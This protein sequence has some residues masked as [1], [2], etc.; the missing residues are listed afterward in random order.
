[1]VELSVKPVDTPVLFLV[2]TPTLR[3][4]ESSSPWSEIVV[5]HQPI[6]NLFEVP[7]IHFVELGNDI[8][9]L[10]LVIRIRWSPQ[11][12]RLKLDR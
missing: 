8:E 6:T 10:L 4:I 7:T 11:V 1:V 2:D 3:L 12:R 9:Q 5:L